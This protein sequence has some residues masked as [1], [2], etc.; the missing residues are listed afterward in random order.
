VLLPD[1]VIYRIVSRFL[2]F[3]G[4]VIAFVLGLL[5]TA[6]SFMPLILHE[7]TGFDSES[8]ASYGSV[9]LTVILTV[10]VGTILFVLTRS[11]CLPGVKKLL[12]NL[13]A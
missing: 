13:E 5:A 11:Y 6:A 9:I 12:S 8:L 10:A 4:F 3:T 7:T 2:T 1:A